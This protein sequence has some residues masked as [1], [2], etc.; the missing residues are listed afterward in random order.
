MR[1]IC[2]RKKVQN[3]THSGLELRMTKAVVTIGGV[4]RAKLPSNRHYRQT[5][6]QL[7]TGRMPF[8]S[9]TNS[10]RAVKGKVIAF[11]WFAH[12]SSPE[13][14]QPDVWPLEAPGYLG[15]GGG[16]RVLI[17]HFT[18]LLTYFSSA[19]WRQ[20][21]IIDYSAICGN[22]ALPAITDNSTR[23]AGSRHTTVPVKRF[24]WNYK[25]RIFY[26]TANRSDATFTR[27]LEPHDNRH[28][29]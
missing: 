25:I 23:G 29:S 4:K 13:V 3:V 10:L 5:N 6:A 22:N 27:H 26:L 14:F 12:Q 21:R 20:S 1:L 2:T 7:F 18:Y 16:C 28:G 17:A 15:G 19:S 24:F 8:L 9:P 11:H